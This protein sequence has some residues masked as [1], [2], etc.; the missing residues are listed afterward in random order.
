MLA[1]EEI[2]I[3]GL[4]HSGEDSPAKFRH[5]TKFGIVVFKINRVVSLIVLVIRK[6]IVHRIRIDMSSSP[7]IGAPRKE[8]RI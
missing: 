7:L 6:N 4:V 3:C 1:V 2:V 8:K 5:N